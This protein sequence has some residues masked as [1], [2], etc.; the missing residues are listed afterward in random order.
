MGHDPHERM[1]LGTT[2]E[3]Q[4]HV[5]GTSSRC[6]NLKKFRHH[7]G[8]F[9]L[10]VTTLLTISQSIVDPQL[11]DIRVVEVLLERPEPRHGR[12]R[13]LGQCPRLT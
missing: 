10:H 1:G 8:R 5:P 2:P 9:V 4:D 13:V 6:E 3:L 11:L 12:E 7:V